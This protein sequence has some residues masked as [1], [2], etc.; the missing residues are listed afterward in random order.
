VKELRQKNIHNNNYAGILGSTMVGLMSLMASYAKRLGA[1]DLQITLITT[2]P[3]LVAVFT[4]IPGSYLIDKSR[5]KIR[6]SVLMSSISRIFIILMAMVPW[7][8]SEWQAWALVI[9]LALRNFPESVWNVAYQSIVGDVFDHD[10]LAMV[11]SQRNR[12]TSIASLVSIF[13]LSQAMNLAANL[14][15]A[16]VNALQLVLLC[17]A[18]FGLWELFFVAR[19]VPIRNSLP[20]RQ[21]FGDSLQG[22]LK[23]LNQQKRFLGYCL[24]VLPFYIAW[25]LPAALFNLYALNQLHAS[26]VWMSY[27]G[28]ASSIFSIISLPLWKKLIDN[29]GYS[30]ALLIAVVGMALTPLVYYFSTEMWHLTLFQFIPGT[31][32]AGISLILF[33]MLIEM[34]PTY[35]RTLYI[36]IFTTGV[37][38]VAFIMPTI[39][40]LT[41]QFTSI[42]NLMLITFTLR[43]MAGI[44]LATK[45]NNLYKKTN[46][47]MLVQSN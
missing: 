9:L 42:Q 7:L 25:M 24:M 47:E 3:A 8:P 37:Q 30:T 33:N 12:L 19:F 23:N 44:W 21:S 41:L 2:L 43:V 5:Q 16:P 36:A 34:T 22:V 14:G 10:D 31:A 40:T 26:E 6:I 4:L 1:T 39:G 46:Q 38:L 13:V 45:R 18:V 20:V 15:F 27:V 28:V 32:V 35:Q 17:A 29:K 11:M